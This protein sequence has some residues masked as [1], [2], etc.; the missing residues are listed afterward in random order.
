MQLCLYYLRKHDD[1]TWV[2][3]YSQVLPWKEKVS[4][5]IKTVNLKNLPTEESGN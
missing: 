1:Y 5:E 4:N 3:T 2:G